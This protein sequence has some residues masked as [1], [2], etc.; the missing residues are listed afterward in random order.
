MR[1]VPV[2]FLLLAIWS[3]AIPTGS[4][5]G[6][7]GPTGQP[8]NGSVFTDFNNDGFADLAI[9]VAGEDVGAATQAGAVNVLYGSAGGLQATSPDDQFW[10][11]DSPGVKDTAES[12]D[13]FR[14]TLGAGN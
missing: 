5:H 7:A 6:S 1:R 4:A 13:S 3:W 8:T 14:A 10:N 2:L 11:Q 9:G 12:S